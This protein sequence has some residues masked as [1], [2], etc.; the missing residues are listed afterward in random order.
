MTPLL[1]ADKIE[2]TVPSRELPILFETTIQVNKEEFIVLL[3][4]NGSGKSTLVK[5]LS[6][7]IKASAG[8]VLIDNIETNQFSMQQKAQDIVVLA[9]KAE[10]RLFLDLT[11]EENIILW[12]SRYPVKEQL[13]FEQVILF[14]NMPKR[15]LSLKK[16]QMKNFSGGEK[17]SILLALALAHPPKI[18]FL[19]EHTASLDYKASNEIMNETN[20]AVI[21]HKITTIMVTHN[22]DYAIDYGDR[23]IVMKEGRI[24]VDQKKSTAIRKNELKEMMEYKD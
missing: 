10:D 12:E 22:L 6:G 2:L 24:M 8:K 15:F 11:L 21:D 20:R 7:D 4:H 9:Q 1:Y 13:R 14:A 18:L 17:Q 5:L 16:Q 23:I 3:G 19:D